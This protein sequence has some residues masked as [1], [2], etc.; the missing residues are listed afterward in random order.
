MDILYGM[1]SN[2]KEVGPWSDFIVSSHCHFAKAL[3]N[4]SNGKVAITGQL[5]IEQ[6]SVLITEEIYRTNS[7][8]IAE[9]IDGSLSGR[10]L[11]GRLPNSLSSTQQLGI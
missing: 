10:Q 6:T 2:F 3:S 8:S 11:I 5:W 1:V 4:G 7:L 9:G